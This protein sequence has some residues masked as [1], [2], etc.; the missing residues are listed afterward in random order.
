MFIE[1]INIKELKAAMLAFQCFVKGRF[2]TTTVI[3]LQL[4][5]WCAVQVINKFG[6][7]KNDLLNALADELWHDAIAKNGHLKATYLPGR[8]N[9]EADWASRYFEDGG[10]GN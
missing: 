3:E 9:F 1:H 10:I 6:S 4:D 7:F 5:N 2:I 8:E